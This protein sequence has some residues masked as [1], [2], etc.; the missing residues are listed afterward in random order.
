M[1]C[2][3]FDAIKR[4]VILPWI[5]WSVKPTD[6]YIIKF[7][8]KIC[9][10]T[11]FRII[12]VESNRNEIIVN[13]SI[14]N[15]GERIERMLRVKSGLKTIFL[16]PS[17]TLYT[18]WVVHCFKLQNSYFVIEHIP[19]PDVQCLLTGWLIQLFFLSKTNKSEWPFMI[20]NDLLDRNMVEPSLSFIEAVQHYNTWYC[21]KTILIPYIT[22]EK[23]QNI[24][25]LQGM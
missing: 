9:S 14:R 2:I 1:S 10:N 11:K 22:L 21:I 19:V 23:K 12:I 17:C 16:K 20:L 4:M 6:V 8:I 5:L 25:Q 24:K 3:S 13:N 15:K 18:T 7:I